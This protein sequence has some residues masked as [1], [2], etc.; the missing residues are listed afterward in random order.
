[1][2]PV[3]RDQLINGDWDASPDS[4]YRKED[5][6]FY[7]KRSDYIVFDGSSYK[8]NEI[9]WFFTMDC[10]ATRQEMQGGDQSVIGLWGLSPNFHLGLFDCKILS[11]EIPDL[12]DET[13]SLY[14]RYYNLSPENFLVEKN[15]V[16]LGVSQSMKA[17][18]LPVLEI[19]KSVDKV[20]F[21][22]KGIIKMSQNR[23]FLPEENYTWKSRVE[24]QLF[25]WQGLKDEPDDIV[26]MVSMA[27][28]YIDWSTFDASYLENAVPK[29][30]KKSHSPLGISI[31]KD[32]DFDF[33]SYF[34]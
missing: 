17:R 22:Q 21:A 1:M 33:P 13:I 32:V 11:L 15:G 4:L 5:C 26:D 19:H 34:N 24:E 29:E 2:D 3:K 12:V 14:R 31:V 28:H 16:G 20:Q 7:Q 25:V 30:R 27:A 8:P 6:R 10:A 18:G 9:K 23:I